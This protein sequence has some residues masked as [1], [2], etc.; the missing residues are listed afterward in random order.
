MSTQTYLLPKLVTSSTVAAL[1]TTLAFSQKPPRDPKVD[2]ELLVTHTQQRHVVL[3]STPKSNQVP[4]GQT[5]FFYYG[6]KPGDR[7][8]TGA[9]V[10]KVTKV[11]RM[12]PDKK[13]EHASKT[14]LFRNKF[15][16]PNVVEEFNS[17]IGRKRYHQ[18]HDDPFYTSPRLEQFHV[19]YD[20][21]ERTNDPLPRRQEFTYKD[22][23]AITVQ[24]VYIISYK[25]TG[26]AG[27]GTWIDFTINLDIAFCK[28]SLAVIDLGLPSNNGDP[29]VN[30]WEL[31]A[32][33]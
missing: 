27:T 21:G 31:E 18:Y 12:E 15:S 9:I 7:S 1:L 4:F 32:E 19:F 33:Q 2:R 11:Y 26:T 17:Q 6:I 23:N 8:K 3:S 29:I 28:A 13:W 16:F 22:N 24:K 10:A 20:K 30:T 25:G 5:L 14:L